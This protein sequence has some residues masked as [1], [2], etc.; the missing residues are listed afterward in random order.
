ME[1]ELQKQEE[2]EREIY[3]YRKEVYDKK[4]GKEI[5]KEEERDI[6]FLGE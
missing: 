3:K 6:G 4:D 1:K 2:E 5:K